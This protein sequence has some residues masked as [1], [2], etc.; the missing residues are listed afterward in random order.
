MRW[1]VFGC[2]YDFVVFTIHLFFFLVLYLYSRRAHKTRRHVFH[3]CRGMCA[4]IQETH[5]HP[6]R[7]KRRT[8]HRQQGDVAH[9]TLDSRPQSSPLP[10]TSSPSTLRPFLL[11]SQHVLS[12]LPP[13]LAY[14]YVFIR[15]PVHCSSSSSFPLSLHVCSRLLSPSAPVAALSSCFLFA[16]LLLWV[17]VLRCFFFLEFVLFLFWDS[18]YLYK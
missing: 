2:K 10:F 7:R 8:P 11:P 9:N 5:S 14:L 17:S 3:C 13:R 4:A 16:L 1:L 15:T 12:Y 18:I 6:R